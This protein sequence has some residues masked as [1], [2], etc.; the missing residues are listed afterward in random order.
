MSSSI[1]PTLVFHDAIAEH[2]AVIQALT[3][4]QIE[5]K[6]IAG[7]MTHAIFEGKKVFWCG[8]GESA[9]DSQH[10]AAELMGRFRRKRRGLPS[11]ALRT[12]TPILTAIGNDFR[13]EK[14]FQRQ[15]E[16]HCTKGDVLVGTSTSGNG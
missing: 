1:N 9:A 10:L 12:D 14:V 8:N 15:V 4:Q 6:R 5:L 7:E 13:C 16:T 11:V 3:A 2:L